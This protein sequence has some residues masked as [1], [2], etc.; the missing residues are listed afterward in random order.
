MKKVP[1]IVAMPTG[2]PIAMAMVSDIDSFPT[3]VPTGVPT[4]IPSGIPTGVPTEVPPG[5][6][7]EVPS[8]PWVV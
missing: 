8:G 2:T 7:P 4:G 1:N 6:P 5:V 3:G